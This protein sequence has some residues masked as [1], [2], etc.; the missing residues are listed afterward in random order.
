VQ[1]HRLIPANDPGALAAA[2]TRALEASDGQRF[3]EADR[4]QAWI[5]ANFSVD[6]MTTIV[7]DGY[8]SAQA[9][10]AGVRPVPA[11]SGLPAGQ[12]S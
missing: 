1:A 7:L 2:M 12:R 4:L 3:A 11:I 8:E 6:R 10:K 9:T 5:A